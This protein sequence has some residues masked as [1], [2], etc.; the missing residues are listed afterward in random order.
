[1]VSITPW[2]VQV[3]GIEIP[4]HGIPGLKPRHGIP[5]LD[6]LARAI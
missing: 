5:N 1:M 2:A 3:I 4:N 6:H